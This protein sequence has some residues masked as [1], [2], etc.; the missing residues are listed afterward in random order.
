[1]S[2]G[3]SGPSGPSGSTGPVNVAAYTLTTTAVVK[4]FQV[5]EV[6]VSLFSGAE[7]LVTL[8]DAAGKRVK[9]QSLLMPK[10]DY[11]HW[12]A[13][14]HYVVTWVAGKLGLTLA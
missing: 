14:D 6:V 9:S 2:T 10:E 11:A 1:M 7:V 13:D 12:L 5:T 8:L 3:P 4:S